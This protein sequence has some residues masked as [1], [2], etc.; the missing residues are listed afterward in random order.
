MK[1]LQSNFTTPE[2]SK[3]LLELGVPVDSADLYFYKTTSTIFIDGSIPKYLINKGA[4]YSVLLD[5]KK[6]VLREDTFTML[7]C[8]SVGRL[9]EIIGKSAIFHPH[10]FLCFMHDEADTLVDHMM[11]SFENGVERNYYDFTRL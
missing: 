5:A 9:I 4:T 1:K 7:P 10:G 11:R 8:W 2:Q 6:R 3:R